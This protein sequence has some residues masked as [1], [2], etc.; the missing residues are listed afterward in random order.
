MCACVRTL[1]VVDPVTDAQKVSELL[2]YP[3]P[4]DKHY[5]G[6]LCMRVRVREW[7]GESVGVGS[8]AVCA[9]VCM[10][11]ARGPEARQYS[12]LSRWCSSGWCAMMVCNETSCVGSGGSS[13]LADAM[14]LLQLASSF[15]VAARQ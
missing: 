9:R 10:C 14:G 13:V 15:T 3:A 12:E 4:D 7:E 6:H 8:T 1:F 5:A 11:D 2:F